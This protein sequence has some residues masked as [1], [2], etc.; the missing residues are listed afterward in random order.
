[1]RKQPHPWRN[2]NELFGF[3][4][5]TSW[6]QCSETWMAAWD[7]HLTGGLDDDLYRHDT[8]QDHRSGGC[9]FDTVKSSATHVL[10]NNIEARS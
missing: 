10:S 8:T 2:A 5:T 3:A 4:A 1:M 9:G 7:R 6:R